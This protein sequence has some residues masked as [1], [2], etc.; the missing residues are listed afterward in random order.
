MTQEMTDVTA[1]LTKYLELVMHP[2]YDSAKILSALAGGIRLLA[3][4]TTMS[5]VEK[6]ALLLQT[7]KDVLYEI[8]ISLDLRDKLIVMVDLLGGSAIDEMVQ[9][10]QDMKTFAKRRCLCF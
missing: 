5:G 9:F 1:D 6:K 2:P 10:G 7:I 3:R 4:V 8:D